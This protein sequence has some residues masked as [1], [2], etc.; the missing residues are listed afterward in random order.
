MLEREDYLMIREKREKGV[1]VKDIV[2]ELGVHPKTVSRALARGSAP[3]G[4]RPRARR[5]KPCISRSA[6]ATE[7][8]QAHSSG[9]CYAGRQPGLA[10]GKLRTITTS[11]VPT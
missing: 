9:S 11:P 4:K 7:S 1:Y 3:S 6:D 5:S 8:I 10:T 2:A